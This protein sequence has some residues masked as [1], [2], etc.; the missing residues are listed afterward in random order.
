MTHIDKL[1]QI[2]KNLEKDGLIVAHFAILDP[3][4]KDVEEVQKTLGCQ[5]DESIIDF[6]HA[7]N[8]VQLL[9]YHKDNTKIQ[10]ELDFLKSNNNQPLDSQWCLSA[11]G[12]SHS[13]DGAIMIAPI[14]EALL[15]DWYDFI[16]F[17]FT[18]NDK[19]QV[20]FAGKE[21]IEPDFSKRIKPFDIYSVYNDM[22]FFLDGTS[23]P[24]VLMGDDQMACYTDSLLTNFTTYL[25]F[26][27]YSRGLVQ[28][29]RNLFSKYMGHHSAPITLDSIAILPDIDFKNYDSDSGIS[30]PFEKTM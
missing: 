6:Y 27:C 4:N 8:G 25:D 26:L 7:C 28:A 12:S 2:V 21:Y 22:A 20:N 30:I 15:A 29:R 10:K 23:N 1:N 14:K 9:W 17:D 5:L 24:A 13:F 19:N 11:L 18:I 3:V 16:Y